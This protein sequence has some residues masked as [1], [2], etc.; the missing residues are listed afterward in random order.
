MLNPEPVKGHEQGKYRPFL[1]VSNETLSD[2]TRYLAWCV[3]ISNTVSGF[4]LHVCL[5]DRTKTTGEIYCEHV[6]AMDVEAR[7]AKKIE[8]CPADILEKVLTILNLCL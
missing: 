5:D 4:P 3:P 6:R 1:V 8:E 7:N 2:I